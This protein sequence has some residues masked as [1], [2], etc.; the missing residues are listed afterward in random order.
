M[1]LQNTKCNFIDFDFEINCCF[2]FVLSAGLSTAWLPWRRLALPSLS[3]LWRGRALR[4]SSASACA[5]AEWLG[6]ERMLRE[7]EGRRARLHPRGT[8]RSLNGKVTNSTGVFLDF[9]FLGVPRRRRPPLQTL[10]FTAP[11]KSRFFTLCEYKTK[12][13]DLH[14]CC[15][16]CALVAPVSLC[17]FC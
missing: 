15:E 13:F 16:F 8:V 7:E 10:K 14:G 4:M 2:V 5:R 12:E 3:R 17:L 9:S 11:L 6:H 1:S